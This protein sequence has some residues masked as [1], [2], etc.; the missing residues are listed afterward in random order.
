MMQCIGSSAIGEVPHFFRPS[1]ERVDHSR[2]KK[3]NSILT[4]GRFDAGGSDFHLGGEAMRQLIW[5]VVIVAGG[6]GIEARAQGGSEVASTPQGYLPAHESA[7]QAAAKQGAPALRAFLMDFP[8]GADLHVHLSGAVYA[9][10]FIRDA[11]ED[12]LCVDPAALELAKPPCTGKL[13]PATQLSGNIS[14]ANQLLYDRLIDS[15]SMR[16]FV[17]SAGWSGHDQ[18][19]ATFGHFGRLSATH[20]AEWV[21]EVASRAASQN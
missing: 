8:K 11:G 13:I 17:P 7:Y 10:T 6:I 2:F 9:E 20:K 12:G 19:F 5:F 1:E 4:R 3:I 15:F 14:A 18:F 16:S 21:D